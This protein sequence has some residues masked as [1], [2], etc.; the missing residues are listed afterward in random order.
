MTVW[1]DPRYAA[2]MLR[3]APAFTAVAVTVLAI[4]IGANSAIFSLVEAVLPRPLPSR[5]AEQ[6]VKVSESPP[7]PAR[8]SVSPLNSLDWSEQNQVFSSM[9]AVSGSSRTLTAVIFCLSGQAVNPLYSADKP[10]AQPDRSPRVPA[11]PRRQP[12]LPVTG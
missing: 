4:G 12:A 5:G 6:L 11:L 9:A 7:G 1:Q 10:H 8:N 2:R 3:Q